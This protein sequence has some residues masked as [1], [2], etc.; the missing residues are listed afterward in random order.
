[1]TS[2]S[3]MAVGYCRVCS[4]LKHVLKIY[5][6]C[7]T[8]GWKESYFLCFSYYFI[9]VAF[10]EIMGILH[11]LTYHCLLMTPS[12]L[13]RLLKTLILLYY[14]NLERGQFYY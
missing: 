9:Y 10:L 14:R 11:F 1:M 4:C 3:I 2:S 6:L 13:Q 7:N 5:I 12:S 8:K